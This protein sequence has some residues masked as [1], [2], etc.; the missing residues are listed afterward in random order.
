VRLTDLK[1]YEV[2]QNCGR[3]ASGS[4]GMAMSCAKASARKGQ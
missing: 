2:R 4:K 1:A 3:P